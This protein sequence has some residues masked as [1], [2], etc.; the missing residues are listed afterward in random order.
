MPQLED[1]EYFTSLLV[2]A[3]KNLEGICL[4]D[5]ALEVME[6][7]VRNNIHGAFDAFKYK[8][9]TDVVQHLSTIFNDTTKSAELNYL[10]N[11]VQ[12]ARNQVPLAIENTLQQL[13]VR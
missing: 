2:D 6:A 5:K 9:Q 10:R 7:T 13:A 3:E 8:M 11:E 4:Q 12:V 1:L